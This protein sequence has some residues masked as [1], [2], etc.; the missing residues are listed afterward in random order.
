MIDT[1]I[2]SPDRDAL[3]EF[4]C[5]FI[6]HIPPVR[7]RAA[8]TITNEDGSVTE[9]EGV[10]DPS[11]WYSCVRFDNRSVAPLI[12]SPIEEVDPAIGSSVV[13]FA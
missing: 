11:L 12:S 5:G 3:C 9:I 10:G 1:Y 6:N 2:S 8:Q 4:T 7:G 13:G